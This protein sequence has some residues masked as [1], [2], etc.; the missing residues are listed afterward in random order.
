M[1]KIVSL[2]ALVCLHTGLKAQ[3]NDSFTG[4]LIDKET[5]ALLSGA[6]I[7]IRQLNIIVQSDE[8]GRFQ[9]T[10]LCP[11]QY[12]LH[13]SFVGYEELVA[14]IHW[15]KRTTEQKF[16]LTRKSTS[17][18]EVVVQN[19]SS[20]TAI[21]SSLQGRAL[22]A[23]KGLSLGE[24]L[25]RITGVSVLQTGSNIYK[26]VI[27]GLH[28]NRILI[29]NNGIRHEGQQ[30][31]SEHAPE[32]DPF[33]ANRLTVI[34]GAGALQYGGDAIAGVI[35]IEPKALP[36]HTGL[37]GEIQSGFFSNN[38]MGVASFQIENRS[39][40]RP[41]QAW[42]LQASGK[43]GGNSKTPDYW[44]DNS[45]LREW[46]FS[47]TWGIKKENKGLEIFYSLFNTRLGIF[48]GAH[49]GNTTD[50]LQAINSGEP[51]ENIRNAGFS[52]AINRPYQ[53]VS[54][55]L[56]KIKSYRLYKNKSKLSATL[57]SQYNQR[58]EYD[59]KR[60]LNSPDGPQLD[61]Q[62]A[63]ISAD[64]VFD[65]YNW[66]GWNGSMG[67][68]G[69]YQNNRYQ[70]RLFIPNYEAINAGIFWIGKKESD[71]FIWEL[72]LRMDYRSYFNTRRNNGRLYPG[73]Q[74]SNLSANG[75]FTFKL[76]DQHRLY[77]NSTTAWRAPQVNEL[78]SDGLHHG[79]ARIERGDSLLKP[80]RST[81]LNAGWQ[82]NNQ[83]WNIEWGLYGKLIRDFIFL[84]PSYPP[85]LTIRGAFPAF[86]YAQTDA[87]L[88]GTDLSVGHKWNAHFSSRFRS[89]IIYAR[90]Q[91]A[92]D[93]LIQ[94][95]P[96]S[97]EL[98]SEWNWVDGKK[99]K[100][101]YVKLT[102]L[103][104]DAQKRI[105]ATGNIEL[106]NPDGSIQMAADYAPPPAAY[107]LVGLET[108]SS[109][110]LSK[111]PISVI[112]SCSNLLNQ[113]YRDYMNAFRY[114]SDETGRN[115]QLR[116]KIPLDL[117]KTINNK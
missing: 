14:H 31:G 43:Y 7:E 107:Y 80:E 62:L 93:W 19:K 109:F 92:G 100:N 15:Q 75:G 1:K 85:Q 79:A 46:N 91:K 25:K 42:R 47:G 97:Y 65:H 74:Y 68:T 94:M 8:Q 41:A 37:I 104:T 73:Q 6:N 18:A 105:P 76:N 17:L 70:F 83:R 67:L 3:C 58:R 9:F 51:P 36:N 56:L 57:S 49:I 90:D 5:G 64:L 52:Y 30:W 33:L 111:T 96:N 81:G 13:F 12:D 78:Y 106:K 22:D 60:F 24:S 89:T 72:G 50:L 95:P 11:G 84:R 71:H 69:S 110:L 40:R 116:I 28:S 38:R 66:R 44:L 23:S 45:A 48:S 77:V 39:K 103:R 117:H 27:H 112:L 29:L 108:G 115:I 34:K 87:L 102:L 98:E 61:L 59:K 10:R 63:T 55:Q 53:A 2:L 88:W 16:M 82:F 20:S 114:F 54:H 35:V 26:P 99:R 21:I 113:R 86:L 32:I 101:S 4:I